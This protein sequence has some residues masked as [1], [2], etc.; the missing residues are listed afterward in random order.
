MSFCFLHLNQISYELELW[1]TATKSE[2]TIYN[3]Y[4]AEL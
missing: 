3:E 4:Q 1:V 2:A